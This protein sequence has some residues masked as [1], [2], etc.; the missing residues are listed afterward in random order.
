M[1]QDRVEATI[2]TCANA[3]ISAETHKLMKKIEDSDTLMARMNKTSQLNLQ[4]KY[5]KFL[6]GEEE[7]IDQIEWKKGMTKDIQK[8]NQVIFVNVQSLI[9]AQPKTLEEAK[10]LVTADYQNSLEKA[11][12]SSLQAKYPVKVY[13]D[14]VESVSKR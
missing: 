2:Y 6:K 5:K 11:W 12:I 4:V 8:E 3:N 10:G 1:W 7:I 14:V 9:P 13:D